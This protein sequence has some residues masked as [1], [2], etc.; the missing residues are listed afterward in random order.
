MFRAPIDLILNFPPPL[1]YIFDETFD[2][3][4]IACWTLPNESRI[5]VF[6]PHYFGGSKDFITAKSTFPYNCYKGISDFA[7]MKSLVPPNVEQ[8]NN[9]P[10]FIWEFPDMQSI[11][12]QKFHQIC[13]QEEVGNLKLNLL[14]PGRTSK[15]PTGK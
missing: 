7:V 9:Y 13:V 14:A 11:Y 10:R 1:G 6:A 2:H 4:S 3:K 15:A 12:G 8:K 5:V